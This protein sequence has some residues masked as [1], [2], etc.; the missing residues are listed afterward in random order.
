MLVFSLD[1]APKY[2]DSTP[3]TAMSPRAKETKNPSF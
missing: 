2:I 1:T 3:S